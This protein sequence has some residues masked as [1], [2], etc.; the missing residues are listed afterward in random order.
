MVDLL[1]RIGPESALVAHCLEQ[2]AWHQTRALAYTREAHEARP[3]PLGAAERRGLQLQALEHLVQAQQL[4]RQAQ[5]ASQSPGQATLLAEHLTR[6]QAIAEDVERETSRGY[7]G[8]AP[9]DHAPD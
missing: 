3:Q 2:A 9:S 5:Q 1:A 7:L 8:E 4:V 6:L